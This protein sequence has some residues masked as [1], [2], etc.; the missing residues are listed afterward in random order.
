M[1]KEPIL[2]PI[3]LQQTVKELKGLRE[4]AIELGACVSQNGDILTITTKGV[5]AH[6][7]TPDKGENA[8]VKLLDVLAPFD[9]CL[10]FI[11]QS[12]RYNDGRGANIN[13]N[14]ER[15]GSL[16]ANLGVAKTIDDSIK[17]VVDIRYP[18][19]IT[20]DE[21]TNLLTNR[22]ASIDGRVTRGAYH[23]PLYVAKDDP[24]IIALLGAYNDVTG[25]KG[26]AITIGGGTYARVL[27][28][29]VAFGPVFPGGESRVHGDDERI[30]LKDFAKTIEIYKEAIKRLCF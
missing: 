28:K 8:L 26:E 29:G 13:F 23:L 4:R 27:P 1:A 17:F 15:S 9:K 7:S 19:C 30:S 25:T 12:F 24:L 16:T 5:S 10:D 3:K 21:L 14:D 20:M 2:S 22:F 11:Y 18:L 6:G